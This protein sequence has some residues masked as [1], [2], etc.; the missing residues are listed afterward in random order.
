MRFRVQQSKWTQETPADP[1]RRKDAQV[2]RSQVWV[3]ADPLRK[4]Q[5]G[6]GE[7]RTWSYVIVL[8]IVLFVLCI[9]LLVLCIVLFVLC[10]VPLALCIVPLALCIVPLVLCIALLA[11]EI[12]FGD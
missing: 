3:R 8:C 9:A 11:L 10:I 2:R 7:P 4:S 1:Q 5:V 12:G 6:G